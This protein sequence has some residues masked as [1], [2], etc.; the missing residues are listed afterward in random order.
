MKFINKTLYLSLLF[1]LVLAFFPPFFSNKSP[2]LK[3]KIESSNK[4]LDLQKI[5]DVNKTTFLL[6][7]EEKNNIYVYETLSPAVVNITVYKTEYFSSFFDAYPQRSEGQGSGAIFD[8]SGLVITN[9]HVVGNADK[10]T[11]ALTSED[12]VYD[13]EI[14][15]SDPE[16]DLAVLKIKNPPDDLVTIN[17]G[18][19]SNLKVGQ[20]VYAIGN[21]FGLDRTLTSGIISGLGRPIKTENGNII[22]GA[23]QTDASINPGNSGGPLLDSGGNMIGINTM[24]ISPSGGSVGL[25]FAIPVDTARDVVSDLINFGY[26]KRGWIDA[27]FLPITPRIARYLNYPVSYGL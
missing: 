23:I 21:P 24:I 20:K 2:F 17:F 27:A 12:K 22:E 14:I 16:N 9:Y 4:S 10:L 7:E 11:V 8:K 15:G 26:V 13:A 19:S 3:Q 6:D 5:I 18:K 1:F 25:G